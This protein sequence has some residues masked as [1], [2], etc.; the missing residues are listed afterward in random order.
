M[1]I[2]LRK[3]LLS[4]SHCSPTLF[5]Q[6]VFL[7]RKLLPHNNYSPTASFFCFLVS[8]LSVCLLTRSTSFFRSSM[9]FSPFFLPFLSLPSEV[10]ASLYSSLPLWVER[11]EKTDKPHFQTR[12]HVAAATVS[13]F[14]LLAMC[15]PAQSRVERRHDL[16]FKKTKHSPRAS[17]EAFRET[18]GRYFYHERTKLH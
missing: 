15:A 1:V 3:V 5:K 6:L 14:P 8:F 18:L 2:K 12:Q 10:A 9:S 16:P 11:G 17:D 7:G 4:S 13:C